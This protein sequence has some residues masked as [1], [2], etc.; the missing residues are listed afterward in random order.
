MRKL[1]SETNPGPV[2]EEDKE[3]DEYEKKFRFYIA[4]LEHSDPG[5]RWKA[6]ESLARLGDNRAVGP[7]IQA[8]SD[9]DWRGTAE[10]GVG[11]R[12]HGRSSG[13]SCIKKSIPRR[14]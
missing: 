12:V 10:N 13:N 2:V 9:E 7:L 14:P 4:M 3:T 11:T 1:S 6:A 5:R 8:L